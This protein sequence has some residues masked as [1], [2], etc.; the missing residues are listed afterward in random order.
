VLNDM[1]VCG[2][3]GWRHDRCDLEI[4]HYHQLA[5]RNRENGRKGGRPKN[6][7]GCHRKPRSNPK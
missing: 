4:A 5:E 3:D 6:P 7:V 1:F 2:D